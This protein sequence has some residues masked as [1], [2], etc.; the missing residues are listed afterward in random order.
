MIL[1][2]TKTEVLEELR[3]KRIYVD[4]SFWMAYGTRPLI[5]KK[6]EAEEDSM[7]ALRVRFLEGIERGDYTV[8]TSTLAEMEYAV[9]IA[10]L[11][12]EEKVQKGLGLATADEVKE[13]TDRLGYTWDELGVKVGR[14]TEISYGSRVESGTFLEWSHEVS[15]LSTCAVNQGKPPK[16]NH[17]GMADAMHVRLAECMGADFILTEDMP[18]EG[19]RNTPI[20]PVVLMPG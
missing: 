5:R 15:R 6:A 10:Q 13:R 9:N 11:V 18:F 2:P 3:D 19:L 4:T 17:L 8:L 14:V 12:S 1:T 7:E 16:L 20:R